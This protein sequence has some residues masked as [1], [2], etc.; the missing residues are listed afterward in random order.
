MLKKK[1]VCFRFGKKFQ[2]ICI[3]LFI[4]CLFLMLGAQLA[5]TMPA[6]RNALSPV[7][8]LETLGGQVEDGFKLGEITLKLVG[9]EPSKDIKILINGEVVALFV[10]K[11]INI[12]VSNNAL[13]E[14]DAVAVK[15]PFTVEIDN[16]NEN[17]TFADNKKSAQIQSNITVLA[18]VFVK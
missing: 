18:R 17:I 7:N 1:I 4:F 6:A 10:Q 15:E 3:S 16:Y 5:L 2:S 11:Q 8:E 14:I 12:T 13:L 9:I